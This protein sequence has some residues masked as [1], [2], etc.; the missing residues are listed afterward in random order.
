MKRTDLILEKAVE[1]AYVELTTSKGYQIAK[2][3]FEDLQKA[4]A[5]NDDWDLVRELQLE[6]INTMYELLKMKSFI[7]FIHKN[8]Y[9]E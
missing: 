4:I 2:K 3:E 7:E 1:N 6:L 9:K 8:D 5:D